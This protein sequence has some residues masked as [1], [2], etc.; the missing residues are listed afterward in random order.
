MQEIESFALKK[1]KVLPMFGLEHLKKVREN[2]GLISAGT[3][4]DSEVLE[5]SILLH[6]LGVQDWMRFRQDHVQTSI[7]LA[8]KFL[9]S[10]DFPKPKTEAVLHCIQEHSF[11]GKPRTIEA[12]ILHDADLLDN[13]GAIG[14]LHECYALGLEKT[15]FREALS[16]LKKISLTLPSAFFTEK[17]KTLSREKLSF[18]QDFVEQLEKHFA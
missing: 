16:Y 7:A 9:G 17:G 4:F 2:A 18:F 5:A 15:H 3:E 13:I 6:D 11:D 12:K 8:K 1:L 10:I 14:I